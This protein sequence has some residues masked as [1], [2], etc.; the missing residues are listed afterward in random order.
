MGKRYKLD[1]TL[2][3]PAGN[4]LFSVGTGEI[5]NGKLKEDFHTFVAKGL[6]ASKRARPNIQPTIAVL[7]TRVKEPTKGDWEKLVRLMKYLNGTSKMALTL[8]AN[9]LHV[10]WWFVDVA[11]A[12]HPNFK[13]HTGRIMT[14]GKGAVQSSSIK[15]KLV[16]RSTCESEL[17][18][19]DDARQKFYGQNFF[20]KR[21]GISHLVENF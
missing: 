14:M 17:V 2:E 12:V 21:K 16:T 7:S 20:W 6:F 3:T 11:Y 5:L 10:V 9:N 15:Q 4:D 8:S 18:G 19:A 13:S 1:G